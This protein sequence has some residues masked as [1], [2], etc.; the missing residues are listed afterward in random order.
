MIPRDLTD[1]RVLAGWQGLRSNRDVWLTRG[2]QVDNH[3]V[4]SE[5]GDRLGPARTASR[6]LQL[7]GR[8]VCTQTQTFTRV[9]QVPRRRIECGSARRPF[10][11]V[12]RLRSSHSATRRQRAMAAADATAASL[13]HPLGPC[14]A[15]W[16]PQCAVSIPG[17]TCI[18]TPVRNLSRASVP[19]EIRQRACERLVGDF[20]WSRRRNEPPRLLP[21]CTLRVIAP[22]CIQSTLAR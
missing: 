9:L 7:L 16:Q 3:L 17:N 8:W 15:R 20:S 12:E 22:C 10:V 18:A 1:H 11:A 2:L 13:H 14:C 21:A 5:W 4:D 6:P 19:R